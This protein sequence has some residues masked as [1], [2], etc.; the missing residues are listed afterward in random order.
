[1]AELESLLSA[2]SHDVLD[3]AIRD[4]VRARQQGGDGGWALVA[5]VTERL[6]PYSDREQTPG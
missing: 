1:M 4:L 5:Q 2:V 3:P 6:R